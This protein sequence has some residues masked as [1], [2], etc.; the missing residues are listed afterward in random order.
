MDITNLRIA[1]T[2]VSFATFIGI[3]AWA[4]ARRNRQRF[5]EAAAIPFTQD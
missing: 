5:D 4:Y 3:A 1:A 2:L